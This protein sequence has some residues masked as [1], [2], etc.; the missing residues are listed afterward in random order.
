VT[1]RRCGNLARTDDR[2]SRVHAAYADNYPRLAAL[3]KCYDPK[4]LF[5]LNTNIKP[6]V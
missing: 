6:A 2:D 1:R 5:C 3:S 4:N